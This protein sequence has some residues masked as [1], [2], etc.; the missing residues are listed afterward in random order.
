MRGPAEVP[1]YD[2]PIFDADTHIQE[3]D[4]SFLKDYLDPRRHADWLVSTRWRQDGTSW[5]YIGEQQVT[6]V[7]SGSSPD[8]KVVGPGKLKAWLRSMASGETLERVDPT[9]DWWSLPERLKKLDEF[10]VEGSLLFIGSF[11][12]LFGWMGVLAEEKG[13]AGACALFHAYNHYILDEWSFNHRERIYATPILALWDLDWAVAEAKW[14]VEQGARVVV[15]PMG[16]AGG[17]AAADPVYDPVWSI[18][19]EAGVVVTFHISEANF[20]HPLIRAFGEE[21]LQGRRTGQSAWQ[22]QFTFSELPVMM[23]LASC[24][25]YNFFE[26]FPNI[27][28]GSVEN[29][30]EWLPGFLAKMDKMRSWTKLGP[31]PGGRLKARP[32]EI[33]KERCFVVAFPEEDVKDIVERIGCVDPILMGSDYP[34]PEGIETPRQFAAEALAGLGPADVRK[35]MHDNGRRIFPK[36]A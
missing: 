17:K 7:E 5:L 19:N 1:R 25:F 3:K 27:R 35:I 36:S 13:P 20:M 12:G 33:F 2:G 10:G 29:G 32:S 24:V 31:W 9:P 11:V 26:R 15:M 28:M 34:H 16:P 6:N 21:P 30:A 18:L 8:G 23:T 14:L 4:L 22:W